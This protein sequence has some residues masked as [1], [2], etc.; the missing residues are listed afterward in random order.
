MKAD[1]VVTR[2]SY[3]G[4]IFFRILSIE[5]DETALLSGLNYRIIVDAPLADLTLVTKADL[6]QFKQKHLDET[7]NK[8]GSVWLA[9][10]NRGEAAERKLSNMPGKVLHIDAD[11][12][13]LDMCMEQYEKLD[14]PAH[15]VL[16][17]EAEQPERI[18][19]LLEEYMP[20]ILILTGHDALAKDR[21]KE[22]M[23]NYRNTKYFV[24]AVRAARLFQP[25]KDALVIF[26]GACQS[27]FERL[28]AAGANFA[29]APERVLIH[30]LDPV[31]LA[32]RI[33][34]TSVEQII[35]SQAV[36]K[37]TITGEK[38]IGGFQ[39]RGTHRTGSPRLIAEKT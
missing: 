13:F 7:Q 30:A 2:K 29:S 3:G 25:S 39:T 9:G 27:Y 20:D 24:E 1:D 38:G 23:G 35:N 11:K 4:D 36:I 12:D 32:N 31:L 15:G 5:P 26:A 17:S 8:L 10:A 18:Q 28:I 37:D 21:S 34:H 16:L 6:A 19:K 33:A 22:E 14:V